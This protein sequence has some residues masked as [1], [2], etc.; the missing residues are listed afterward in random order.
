ME[1]HP[2][3]FHGFSYEICMS[4]ASSQAL[5]RA[6]E[7]LWDCPELEGPV[8]E[9]LGQLQLA[10]GET[11]LCYTEV[12]CEGETESLGLYMPDRDA[13][14]REQF[15]DAAFIQVAR[16]VFAHEPFLWARWGQAATKIAG[17]SAAVFLLRT[18]L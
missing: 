4:Y 11:V 6:L 3:Y 13:E 17:T 7:F 12:V 8:E 15:I 2:D 10:D 9:R 16:F 1:L 5:Q 14:G 18:V